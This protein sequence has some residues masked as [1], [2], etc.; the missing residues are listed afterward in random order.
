MNFFRNLLAALKTVLKGV[1]FVSSALIGPAVAV[2]AISTVGVAAIFVESANQLESHFR[3]TVTGS[4]DLIYNPALDTASN[5]LWGVLGKSLKYGIHAWTATAEKIQETAAG[6]QDDAGWGTTQADGSE[7]AKTKQGED[8][9]KRNTEK[10][11]KKTS[12]ASPPSPT[13]QR[14]ITSKSI[15]KTIGQQGPAITSK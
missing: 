4:K 6:I 2:L 3:R 7:A 13:P 11:L 9:W 10:I 15:G 1:K 12:A 14:P 5:F 8:E